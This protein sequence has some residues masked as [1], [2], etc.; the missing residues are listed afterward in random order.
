MSEKKLNAFQQF[1]QDLIPAAMKKQIADAH[2]AQLKLEADLA[3]AAAN[4]AP[5]AVAL[6]EMKTKD[7]KV[8]SIAADTP[9]V[10]V[11]V[12]DTTSGTPVPLE[13]SVE[14]EDGSKITAVA[15]KITVYEPAVVAPPMDMTAATT[16]LKAQ[17][18]AEKVEFEK[19]FRADFAT[20]K[21][22]SEENKASLK[23]VNTQLAVLLAFADKVTNS[24][25]AE[26]EVKKTVDV[27]FSKMTPLEIYKYNKEN[28]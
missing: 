6:K 12:M 10:D 3:A 16:A 20:L 19:T 9:A 4:P 21:K 22:E 26:K 7:G 1:V 2:A 15:G 14:L 25:V 23:D 24:P 17:F 13:G 8:L 11:M 27:D 18:A 28:S 5:A